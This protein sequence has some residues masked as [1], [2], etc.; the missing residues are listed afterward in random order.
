MGSNL[1][2]VAAIGGCVGS[3]WPEVYQKRKWW[4]NYTSSN[5]SILALGAKPT[6]DYEIWG[7]YGNWRKG[8]ANRSRRGNYNRKSLFPV[9]K[10]PHIRLTGTVISANAKRG[11]E[12]GVDVHKL[13][14]AW[15][16]IKPVMVTSLSI[17]SAGTEESDHVCL[18]LWT[19]QQL[20][21]SVT[22]K[23]SPRRRT[24]INSSSQQ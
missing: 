5:A 9:S 17:W 7:L 15:Q 24:S 10:N 8:K 19:H 13:H 22:T 12:P 16:T 20:H 14:T 4:M 3:R 2:P 23:L 11:T 6:I 21:W 18:R 1:L